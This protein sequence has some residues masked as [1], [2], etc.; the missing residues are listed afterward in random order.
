MAAGLIRRIFRF[1]H[2]IRSLRLDALSIRAVVEK[3]SVHSLFIRSGV[4]SSD[5]HRHDEITEA[6]RFR[7]RHE[8]AFWRRSEVEVNFRI[9]EIIEE[10]DHVKKIEANIEVVPLPI[11]GELLAR[12]FLFRITALNCEGAFSE[13]PANAVESFISQNLYARR[14]RSSSSRLID[15]H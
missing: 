5:T 15:T 11:D 4:S 9:F 1:G 6:R 8:Y 7:H 14:A 10:L 12:F 13:K 2:E 3:S